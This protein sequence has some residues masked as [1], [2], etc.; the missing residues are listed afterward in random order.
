LINGT[1][2]GNE[3]PGL[4]QLCA[5]DQQV[6][7]G[8]N[9]AA[10][11]FAHLDELM[12]LVTDKDGDVDFF[13]MN[14]RTI[15]SYLALLRTQG[16]AG[17]GETITLPGGMAAMAY[18]GVPILRNDYIPITQTKG[19]ATATT[20]IFAGTFD[21][22]SRTM[23]LSGL[24]AEQASG[25][26]VIDAGE[27]EDSDDQIYKVKWYCGLALFSERGLAMAPGITN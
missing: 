18:R 10:L 11:S 4:I 12:S 19:N 3:F 27:A 26:Q 7:T 17:I 6:D 15:N 1:G 22:G 14:V 8:V 25:I 23:G 21:D 13:T 5:N 16:G 2:A 20:T 9:G 24:T